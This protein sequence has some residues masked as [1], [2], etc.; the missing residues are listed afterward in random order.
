MKQA[1][2]LLHKSR[3]VKRARNAYA[4]LSSCK[5]SPPE[6]RGAIATQRAA[7]GDYRF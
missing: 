7:D 1:K 3:H 2:R 5:F 4:A 6:W